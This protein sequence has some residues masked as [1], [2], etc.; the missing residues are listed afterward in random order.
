[1]CHISGTPAIHSLEI[2]RLHYLTLFRS[3][4][5]TLHDK[6]SI[7]IRYSAL[8]FMCSIHANAII[9]SRCTA[10]PY[11]LADIVRMSADVRAFA[12]NSAMVTCQGLLMLDVRRCNVIK[13]LQRTTGCTPR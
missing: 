3:A 5:F 4:L 9:S 1:M 6:R 11:Q 7:A 12:G 10:Q 8:F 2:V 13:S